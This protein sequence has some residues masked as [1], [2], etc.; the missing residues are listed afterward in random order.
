MDYLSVYLVF[1]LLCFITPIQASSFE[2]W[3]LCYFLSCI[4][5]LFQDLIS[6]DQQ[7][8]SEV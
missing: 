3:L 5:M 7:K 2:I 4:I 1:C 8:K 6:R